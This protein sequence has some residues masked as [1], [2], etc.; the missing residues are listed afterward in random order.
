MSAYRNFNHDQFLDPKYLW[1][2]RVLLLL[3][4]KINKI[5]NINGLYSAHNMQARLSGIFAQAASEG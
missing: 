1:N 2:N 3:F 4:K 5:I